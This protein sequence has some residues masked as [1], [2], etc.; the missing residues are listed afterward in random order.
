MIQMAFLPQIYDRFS[1]KYN[2][3][4]FSNYIEK[5]KRKKKKHSANS[6]KKVLP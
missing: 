6:F 1:L 2:E 3:T 5:E 4:K